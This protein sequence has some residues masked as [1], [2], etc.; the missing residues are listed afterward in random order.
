MLA[1]ELR[2]FMNILTEDHV[3]VP[4]DMKDI[5]LYVYCDYSN[6]EAPKHIADYVKK[7]N[8]NNLHRYWRMTWDYSLGNQTKFGDIIDNFDLDG[9]DIEDMMDKVNKLKSGTEYVRFDYPECTYIFAIKDFGDTIAID[10]IDGVLHKNIKHA[11]DEEYDQ[12]K[13]GRRVKFVNSKDIDVHAGVYVEP[14]MTGTIVNV[15]PGN[16][17]AVK[18]DDIIDGLE[19]WDNEVHWYNDSYPGMDEFE[20]FLSDVEFI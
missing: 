5:S 17:I 2:K 11:S 10:G 4:D 14:G 16:L 18:M 8:K 1:E 6:T 15:E 3:A 12:V 9:D 20:A 7:D 13:V 19:E